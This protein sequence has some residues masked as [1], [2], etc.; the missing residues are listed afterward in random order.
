MQAVLPVFC[1]DSIKMEIITYHRDGNHFDKWVK[2][3]KIQRILTFY[4]G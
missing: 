2:T 3:G 1:T 4:D